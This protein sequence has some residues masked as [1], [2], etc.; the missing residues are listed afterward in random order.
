MNR[1]PE[2]SVEVREA[3]DPQ[4]ALDNKQLMD[5]MIKFEREVKKGLK[6]ATHSTAEVKCFV[7]YVQDLP[8]G[9]ERGKFLA[10]DLGGTNFR[11]LLIHLKGEQDYEFQSKI[12][13][14]PQSIMVGSGTDLFD[15]IA[16]CLAEFAHEMNIQDEILPLGFTFS[17]PCQQVGLTKGLLIKWTKGFNCEGVANANVVELLEDAIRRRNVSQ[18]KSSTRSHKPILNL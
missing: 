18:L 11:V 7:T 2:V 17:F 5:V 1:L 3:I 14:I 12:F 8:D 4:L 13:A 15:H 9:N 16:K 10:L 6:K